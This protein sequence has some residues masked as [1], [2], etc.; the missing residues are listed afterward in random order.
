MLLFECFCCIAIEHIPKYVTRTARAIGNV[1][2]VRGRE[3]RGVGLPA[4]KV[5]HPPFL[6]PDILLLCFVFVLRH[7][8]RDPLF[9]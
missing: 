8:E 7:D 4:V 3:Y 9:V 2:Y 5:E 6:T 1:G